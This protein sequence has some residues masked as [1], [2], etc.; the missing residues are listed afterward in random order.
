MFEARDMRMAS[1]ELVDRGD[2]LELHLEVPGI[3]KEN[4]MSRQPSILRKS[5]ANIQK[6]MNIRAKDMSTAKGCS[7][8]SLYF[9]FYLFLSVGI[10]RMKKRGVIGSNLSPIPPNPCQWQSIINTDL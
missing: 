6:K 1:Y 4:V 2:R 5:Q 9:A 8:H 10:L 7:A 3:E